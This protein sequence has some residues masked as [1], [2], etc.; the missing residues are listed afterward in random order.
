MKQL[1]HIDFHLKDQA[2]V[3]TLIDFMSSSR[4]AMVAEGYQEIDHYV[5]QDNPLHLVYRVEWTSR[6]HYDKAMA[7]MFANQEI[8]TMLNTVLTEPATSTFLDK[9][10]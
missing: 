3:D 2:G 7:K 10:K 9:I 8:A 1:L 6:E 4:E 5:N